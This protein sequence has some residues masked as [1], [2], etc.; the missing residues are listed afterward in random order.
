MRRDPRPIS[1]VSP[2]ELQV[3]VVIRVDDFRKNAAHGAAFPGYADCVF[4][5]GHRVLK[6]TMAGCENGKLGIAMQTHSRKDL[7]F[8]VEADY[9]GD[10]SGLG[11]ALGIGSLEGVEFS[12]MFGRLVLGFFRPVGRRRPVFYQPFYGGWFYRAAVR[13]AKN[14]DV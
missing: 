5:I 6:C 7:G 12:E 9:G 2:R 8:G 3:E 4:G 1:V 11:V 13:K 10:Q 14:G